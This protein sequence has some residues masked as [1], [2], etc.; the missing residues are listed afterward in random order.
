[1]VLSA[2]DA[3]PS[4]AS[5]DFLMARKEADIWAALLLLDRLRVRR[6][7]RRTLPR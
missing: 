7:Y 1:M 4:S 3:L 6:R 2:I 5:V